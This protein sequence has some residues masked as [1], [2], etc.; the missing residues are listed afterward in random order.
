M[1]AVLSTLLFISCILAWS[2]PRLQKAEIAEGISMLVPEELRRT[3]PTMQRSTS[4][5]LAIFNS[6]DGQTDLGVNQAQLRWGAS[7][8]NLLSQFYKANILNLYDNVTM[9]DEGIKEIGGR[10]FITFEFTGTIV[11]EENAFSSSRKKSDYTYIMY[12]INESGVLIF[13]FTSPARRRSYW[14]KSVREIMSSVEFKEG[15]KKRR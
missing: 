6:R 14:Q 7:D 13:R 1:K 8:V 12:T 2:Q 3:P 5:A 10:Q 9:H 4:P 15:R 11:D